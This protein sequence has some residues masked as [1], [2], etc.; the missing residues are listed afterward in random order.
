MQIKSTNL[1]YKRST[2]SPRNTFIL[3]SK[4]WRS[5]SRITKTVPAWVFALVWVLAS[6]LVLFSFYC[7]CVSGL[8]ALV[9]QH[10]AL[11]WWLKSG[12]VS[13]ACLK[14]E[15][16]LHD[17]PAQSIC[18]QP[19][20]ASVSSCWQLLYPDPHSEQQIAYAVQLWDT[21]RDQIHQDVTYRVPCITKPAV[22]QFVLILTICSSR[23]RH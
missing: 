17:L 23:P 9:G 15:C 13:S 12:S 14:S 18:R 16:S 21:S 8:H 19:S 3:G 6:G 4:Y 1:T 22:I 5:R 10:A 7:K 11:T 2:M 20:A